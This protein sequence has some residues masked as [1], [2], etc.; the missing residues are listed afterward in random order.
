MPLISLEE[1][2]S[3]SRITTLIFDVDMTVCYPDQ[4]IDKELADKLTTLSG[5]RTIGLISGRTAPNLYHRI[6]QEVSPCYLLGENGCQCLH[7]PTLQEIYNNEL[8]QKQQAEI[9]QTL[10]KLI[11]E[12]NLTSCRGDLIRVGSSGI[13]LSCVGDIAPRDI[14]AEY[15]PNKSKRTKLSKKIR[16]RFNGEYHIEIGGD[17]SID[18]TL[19]N[20]GQGIV[21]FAHHLNI[22]LSQILF[23]GDQLRNGNDATAAKYV[24]C[25]EVTNP[26]YTL[27]LLN[28][29]YA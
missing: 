11:E 19:M 21:I 8:N 28:Q 29:L 7:V 1:V 23:M 27:H 26:E 16:K 2:A 20:K 22:N 9:T 14:K 18:I 13:T 4:P 24:D 12:E 3:T 6:A 17:S 15:D 10:Q 5:D 25:L